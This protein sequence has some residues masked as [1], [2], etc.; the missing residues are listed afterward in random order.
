[1][2][3]S[4]GVQSPRPWLLTVGLGPLCACLLDGNNGDPG[5]PV[6][7]RMMEVTVVPSSASVKA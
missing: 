6:A 5:L 1:M 4:R 3:N 7:A 2:S